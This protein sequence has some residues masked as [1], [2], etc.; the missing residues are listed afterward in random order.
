M[1]SGVGQKLS[2]D[3]VIQF[4]ASQTAP[5]DGRMLSEVVS[6]ANLSHSEISGN[7]YWSGSRLV[8]SEGC[9]SPED[10]I[11]ERTDIVD[12]GCGYG[13]NGLLSTALGGHGIDECA[14]PGGM[15]P[16]FQIK[17]T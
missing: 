16:V 9:Y 10:W 11:V 14:F 17:E 12:P 8:T 1:R 4:F 7:A 5:K 13:T 6:V 15:T 3:A 2:I